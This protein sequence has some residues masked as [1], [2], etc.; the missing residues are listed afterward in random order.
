MPE[1]T[2]STVSLAR[3][4]SHHSPQSLGACRGLYDYRLLPICCS[5]QDAT[6]RPLRSKSSGQTV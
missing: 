1:N 2:R 6:H 3:I 4:G 5:E